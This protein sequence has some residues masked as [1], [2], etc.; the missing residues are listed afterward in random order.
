MRNLSED[1]G[2]EA[3]LLVDAS[4]AF[5][6]LN[7]E[8]SLRNICIHYRVLAAMLTNIYKTHCMLF[9]DANHILSQEGTTQGDLLAMTMYAIAPYPL[10]T[11]CRARAMSHRIGTLMMCLQAEKH[12]TC[13]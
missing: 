4:N 6:S 1:D 13:T 5:S 3:V 9:I 8:A 11:S 12:Q 2:V 7:R 10:S